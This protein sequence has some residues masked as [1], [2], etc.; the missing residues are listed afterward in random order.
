MKKKELTEFDMHDVFD[1]EVAP[2]LKQL[3]AVC[4]VHK[5]PFF[6]S[7]CIEN[8][9][10]G[11]EYFHDGNLCG[12]NQIVLKDDK[13]TDF[14]RILCGFRLRVDEKTKEYSYTLPGEDIELDMD[15]LSEY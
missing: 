6:F 9:E 13:I 3:K 15:S 12:S 2:L 10:E 8:S 5:I 7:A 14:L 4:K 11:S 1:A